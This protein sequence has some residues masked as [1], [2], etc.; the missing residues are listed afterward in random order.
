MIKRAIKY[1]F[2]KIKRLMVPKLKKFKIYGENG[3][4]TRCV[5]SYN[6]YGKYC[7]P[8]SS[9]HRPVSR[10]ILRGDVWEKDTI[11]YI[12]NFCNK[13][14]II[15][16]G[17]YFGDFLPALSKNSFN[18]FKIWAFEPNYESYCCTKYTIKL[19]NLINVKLHNF[20]LGSRENI[21]SLLVKDLDGKNKGGSSK[22]ISDSSSLSSEFVDR[23]TII[24][25]DKFIPKNRKIS[26]IHLDVEGYE[27]KALEGAIKII[28]SN[29][30]VIILETL[31]SLDWLKSSLFSMGYS[32]V[33][34]KNQNTILKRT[35]Y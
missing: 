26:L 23:V 5:L 17:T 8:I 33:G 19:N 22:I 10:Y 11:D 16:A 32:V 4:E 9:A 7:V 1:G 28:E 21:K 31:P 24:S 3:F 35:D 34:R 29:S 14:D 15:H 30:P 25:L 27:E 20:G 18:R 12:L 13:G 2:K 6:K